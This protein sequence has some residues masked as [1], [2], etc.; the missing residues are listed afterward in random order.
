MTMPKA[1]ILRAP[2]VASLLAAITLA[3]FPATPM[4]AQLPFD[5]G[6]G[7]LPVGAPP[8]LDYEVPEEYRI[9]E[10]GT[11]TDPERDPFVFAVV[12]VDVSGSR[13]PH[14]HFASDTGAVRISTAP[15]AADSRLCVLGVKDGC[16]VLW[17]EIVSGTQV[18]KGATVGR[19]GAS[20][21]ITL[22]VDEGT[23]IGSEY[24]RFPIESGALGLVHVVENRVAR[25]I[26]FDLDHAGNL[27]ATPARIGEEVIPPASIT[28]ISFGR[29]ALRLDSTTALV[30]DSTDGF[31]TATTSFRY[32]GTIDEGSMICENGVVYLAVDS[33][34]YRYDDLEASAPSAEFAVP[35]SHLYSDYHVVLDRDASENRVVAYRLDG[36]NVPGNGA[37]SGYYASRFI[38]ESGGFEHDAD[39]DETL[40]GTHETGV[41]GRSSNWI[42][43]VGRSSDDRRLYA[44]DIQW[45]VK[46]LNMGIDWESGSR[47]CQYTLD[48][49]GFRPTGNQDGFDQLYGKARAT[50]RTDVRDRN[51]AVDWSASSGRSGTSRMPTSPSEYAPHLRTCHVAIVDSTPGVVWMTDDSAFAVPFDSIEHRTRPTKAAQR[52]VHGVRPLSGEQGVEFYRRVHF[53]RIEFRG[54]YRWER[55]VTYRFGFRRM[56]DVSG[57][58]IADVELRRWDGSRE[59]QVDPPIIV[60][61]V[62]EGDR[63]WV[64]VEMRHE[65]FGLGR[66]VEYSLVS[67]DG[68]ESSST[69]ERFVY[70]PATNPD[71]R[72]VVP[73]AHDSVLLVGAD[74]RAVSFPGLE[75]IE[76]FDVIDGPTFRWRYHP[77]KRNLVRL[78]EEN[79]EVRLGLYDLLGRPLL[80]RTLDSKLW[81]DPSIEVRENDSAIVVWCHDEDTLRA[82]LFDR[83]LRPAAV[84]GEV[85]PVAQMKAPGREIV[86]TALQFAGDDAHVAAIVADSTGRTSLY[87]LNLAVPTHFGV[88]RTD[89]EDDDDPPI[90][91]DETDDRFEEP[92]SI[93]IVAVTP[94]PGY[95]TRTLSITTDESRPVTLA[96]LD[97]RGVVV[98]RRTIATYAGTHDYP[99]DL[100]NLDTGLYRLVV[101]AGNRRAETVVVH[102]DE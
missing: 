84:G 56:G 30:I 57:R 62:F 42:S 29:L 87:Y 13:E 64:L 81:Y 94:N 19:D 92:D 14:L 16:V 11:A 17:S 85:I 77:V 20:A 79:G 66:Q 52:S 10:V 9:A 88:E 82:Q 90:I 53:D 59:I 43:E 8:A 74:N 47:S 71:Y 86:Q 34:I 70:A 76:R 35:T 78:Y 49:G 67:Y 39:Y 75:S 83:S 91:D 101:T 89:D 12:M 96:V 38:L 93:V 33:V 73:V 80:S 100:T 51:I 60:D 65:P 31:R 41:L 97:A 21:P 72:F 18:L 55:L 7:W 4:S 15:V 24:Y 28:A 54:K 2:S 32:P 26:L 69:I 5:A 25:P 48:Q 22:D 58:D 63:M 99:L 68:A 102:Y 61:A 50:Y 3:L 40:C 23:S 6:S 1:I 44:I 36:Y 46:R 45:S 27:R 95:R 37:N 98:R